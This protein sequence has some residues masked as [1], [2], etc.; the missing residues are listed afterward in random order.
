MNVD[1][2]VIF[3]SNKFFDAGIM[4]CFLLICYVV[5]YIVVIKCEKL[6]IL[7][8]NEG[9]APGELIP[10]T[11]NILYDNNN[12]I[13]NDW[14]IDFSATFTSNELNLNTRMIVTYNNNNESICDI[15]DIGFYFQGATVED[16]NNSYP[17]AVDININ[18]PTNTSALTPIDFDVP[19]I[20]W[21]VN[22]W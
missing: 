10:F 3:E 9:Y 6:E 5:T 18:D 20:A 22:M 1:F 19:I 2:L 4:S 11:F 17:V 7:L 13:N 14:N 12:L 16:I 8:S 21:Y 15:C